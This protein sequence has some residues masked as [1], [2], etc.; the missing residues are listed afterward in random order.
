[1]FKLLKDELIELNKEGED[2]LLKWTNDCD[3][4]RLLTPVIPRKNYLFDFYVVPI[5][6]L[7]IW[8]IWNP[9]YIS[10]T[11]EQCPLPM[12]CICCYLFRG[13]LQ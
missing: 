2:S 6:H 10:M 13:P 3:W 8:V 12:Q 4:Q 1:M 7:S 9:S 11:H 5:N